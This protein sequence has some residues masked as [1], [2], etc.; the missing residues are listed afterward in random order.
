MAK[1]ANGATFPAKSCERIRKITALRQQAEAKEREAIDLRDEAKD[2]QRSFGDHNSPEFVKACVDRCL[3]L[4]EIEYQRKRLKYLSRQQDKAVVNAD[5]PTLFEED[6]IDLDRATALAAAAKREGDTQREF[7]D[8][9]YVDD[10]MS[11]DDPIV[12]EPDAEAKN[13]KRRGRGAKAGAA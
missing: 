9:L 6:P 2:R 4:D 13:T 5:Q 10:D 1:T 11:E 7:D 8:D 12:G 3:A